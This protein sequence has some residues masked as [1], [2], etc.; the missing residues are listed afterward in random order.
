[1]LITCRNVPCSA[2]RSEKTRQVPPLRCAHLCSCV[3]QSPNP[4]VN[5]C[6]REGTKGQPEEALTATVRKAGFPIHEVQTEVGVLRTLSTPCGNR[7]LCTGQ[8]KLRPSVGIN[9]DFRIGKVGDNVQAK[10]RW[11]PGKREG[12][13]VEGSGFFVPPCGFRLG[14]TGAPS[15]S[16]WQ[17]TVVGNSSEGSGGRLRR[18]GSSARLVFSLTT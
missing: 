8:E 13:A 18:Q 15:S 14:Y 4:F 3:S 6:G 11:F 9:A 12:C 1:V 16:S 7:E 5:L 2:A 17:R 10:S